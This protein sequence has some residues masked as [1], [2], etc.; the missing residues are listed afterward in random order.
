MGPTLLQGEILL[1]Q[2][3]Q[4]LSLLQEK[5][6]GLSCFGTFLAAT[7]TAG[8]FTLNAKHRAKLAHKAPAHRPSSVGAR[9]GLE[10]RSVM[11]PEKHPGI[12]SLYP[13]FLSKAF[14][15]LL[16][17]CKILVT[18]HTEGLSPWKSLF[19]GMT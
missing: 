1:E 14:S 12:T 11:Y 13:L 2:L 7:G 8:P 5:L 9:L 3:C 15:K 19:W 17:N 18:P 10:A 6:C 4:I 16:W